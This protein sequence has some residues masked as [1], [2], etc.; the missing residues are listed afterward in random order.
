MDPTRGRVALSLVLMALLTLAGC[1]SAPSSQVDPAAAA[2]DDA[3]GANDSARQDADDNNGDNANADH[4]D[5]AAADDA[6]SASSQASDTPTEPTR[7]VDIDFGGTFS[8]VCVPSGVNTCTGP[9]TSLDRGEHWLTIPASALV[10]GSLK[11]TWSSADPTRDALTVRVYSYESCGDSCLAS[12][13]TFAAS[14]DGPSPVTLTLPAARLAE[15]DAGLWIVVHSPVE[16]RGPLLWEQPLPT[17]FEVTG[18]VQI[19]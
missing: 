18:S 19:V 14:A 8:G 13:G 11:L 2:A 4:G 12:S 9:A 7:T 1:L 6:A 10:G 5:G 16:H 15:D 17:D 3:A